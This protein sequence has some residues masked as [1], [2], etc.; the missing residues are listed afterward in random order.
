[1]LKALLKLF[2]LVI[3]W[4]WRLEQDAAGG[5]DLVVDASCVVDVKIP[6]ELLE[7]IMGKGAP[8]FG[9][10]THVT[11]C[12]RILGLP[13]EQF[14]CLAVE[15]LVIG[16]SEYLE[17]LNQGHKLR[18]VEFA[19]L[20]FFHRSELFWRRL[21]EIQDAFV[22]KEVHELDPELVLDL[23]LVFDCFLDHV[24]DLV[25]CIVLGLACD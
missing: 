10:S 2:N 20:S 23:A 15:N 6:Y 21:D 22:H 9:Q 24:T 3:F 5:K 25:D 13:E 8:F 4:N 11:E 17:L 18:N 1:M 14:D 7:V 19:I 12:P 16:A